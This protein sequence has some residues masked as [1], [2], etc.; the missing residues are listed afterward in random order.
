MNNRLTISYEDFQRLS[1]E[2]VEKSKELGDGWQL[3]SLGSGV[4]SQIYLVKRSTQTLQTGNSEKG[5]PDTEEYLENLAGDISELNEETD[6]AALDISAKRLDAQSLDDVSIHMEYH[7][8]HSVSY[9]VP[10]LFFNASYSNGKLLPLEDIWRLLSP[11]FVSS[12]TDKWGLVTQ[13]EHPY[14]GTPFYHIHPCH[15]AEVMGKIMQSFTG[16]D[17]RDRENYLLAWLST[18]ANVV[19]LHMSIKYAFMH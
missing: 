5:K 2:L 4:S 18:F 11:N 13:Q 10:L 3:K 16:V 6:T 7:I 8:L 9:Q 1:I 14:L 17:G 12:D 15:T 19:G